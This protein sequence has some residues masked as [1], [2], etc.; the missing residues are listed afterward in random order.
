MKKVLE[1]AIEEGKFSREICLLALHVMGYGGTEGVVKK[2]YTKYILRKYFELEGEEQEDVKKIVFVNLNN[3]TEGEE[4]GENGNLKNFL[5]HLFE[6]FSKN[7]HTE[8]L[9]DLRFYEVPVVRDMM[10]EVRKTFT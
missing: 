8:W 5:L 7:V 4:T 2:R 10:G 3:L 1:K 9:G 6:D